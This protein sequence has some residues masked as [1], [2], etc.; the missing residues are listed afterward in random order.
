MFFTNY[1][2]YNNSGKFKII[3][4]LNSRLDSSP[5][6]TAKFSK[7]FF[8]L[9]IP[10]VNRFILIVCSSNHPFNILDKIF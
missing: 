5:L 9:Q 6:F 7:N 3:F 4:Q 10:K 1:F 8:N 2:I